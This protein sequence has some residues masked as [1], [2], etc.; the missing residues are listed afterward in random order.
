[1]KSKI[2]NPN[3][4]V[5]LIVALLVV[6][7]LF[8]SSTQQDDVI[9]GAFE[10]M[11]EEQEGAASDSRSS[12]AIERDR[13][14]LDI[15]KKLNEL[16]DELEQC[17]KD[18]SRVTDKCRALLG[19]IKELGVKFSALKAPPGPKPIPT[20][21]KFIAD[22]KIPLYNIGKK[23]YEI[24]IG[25]LDEAEFKEYFKLAKYVQDEEG[26]YYIIIEVDDK[27]KKLYYNYLYMFTDPTLFPPEEH[28]AI[29]ELN[30]KLEGHHGDND[31]V[32]QIIA[33][34]IKEKIKDHVDKD[35]KPMTVEVA[36]DNV[37]KLKV[38]VIGQW[39]E[40]RK[41]ELIDEYNKRYNQNIPHKP[42]KPKKFNA[43]VFP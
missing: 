2:K 4:L 13:I 26:R 20:L 9:V 8:N 19:E 40:H 14:R 38:W 10:Y 41:K 17:K 1:M 7:F 30:K 39:I 32:N 3:G 36:I 29:A 6:L 31:M 12:I 21:E 22:N 37:R 18:S 5:W 34:Y 42:T 33:D 25:K 43:P 15:V 27:P 28:P 11:A 24:I 23:T 35:G 16:D